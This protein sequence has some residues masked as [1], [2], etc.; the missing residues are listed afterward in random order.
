MTDEVK[1]RIDYYV[2]KLGGWPHVSYLE[3]DFGATK[4][5][6]KI[7]LDEYRVLIKRPVMAQSPAEPAKQDIQRISKEQFE[8][9][10]KK[11]EIEKDKPKDT[12]VQHLGG[13]LVLRFLSGLVA[14]A[15]IIRGFIVIVEVNTV[16]GWQGY[17]NAIIFQGGSAILP[18][19]GILSFSFMKKFWSANMVF[20]TFLFIGGLGSMVYEV[21][22]SS[23]AFHQTNVK[24]EI[25][26]Q[27]ELSVD[28]DQVLQSIEDNIK[29]E[30]TNLD[31]I[32]SNL[33]KRQSELTVLQTAAPVDLKAVKVAE[34]RVSANL[35]DRTISQDKLNKLASDKTNRLV[36]LENKT[37]KQSSV[38]NL[39]K[40]NDFI[41]LLISLIPSIIMVI[42]TPIF[43]S[44]ALFGIGKE[45]EKM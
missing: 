13:L 24:Q 43:V 7:W 5:Q 10:S 33:S 3:K 17:L 44:I 16:I 35:S 27:K 34:N 37:N 14:L 11:K 36:E 2:S 26:L 41:Q 19:V 23:Q 29:L 32:N 12:L 22:A 38:V 45:N 30:N 31:Q 40:D 18:V 21:Y 42:F 9:I 6:A 28:R 39:V 4:E 8:A 20:G 1:S 25:V 15:C